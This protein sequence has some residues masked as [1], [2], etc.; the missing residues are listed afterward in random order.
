MVKFAGMSVP[1]KGK[2]NDSNLNRW[3][4]WF[5]IVTD[6]YSGIRVGFGIVVSSSSFYFSIDN[7]RSAF[8]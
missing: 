5:I 7:L 2:I 4:D 6:F 3:I 1:Y 8:F